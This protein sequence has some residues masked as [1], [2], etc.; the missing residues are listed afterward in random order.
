[1]NNLWNSPPLGPTAPIG[2]I[3][4]AGTAIRIELP[5]SQHQLAIERYDALRKHI[6]RLDSPLHDRVR[7]F[8]PQGSMAIRATITSRKRTDGFDIDIIAELILPNSMKP[9]E[10]L[11]ML[12]EAI[13]GP[14]GSKYHG[15]VERQTRCITVYYSDGMHLDVTPTLLIDAY[16]PRL[17]NLFHAKPGEPSAAHRKFLM[18]SFAFCEWF[19]QRTPVDIS[20]EMAY[21][22]R[23]RAFD[24]AAIRADADVEP[25]P[26]HSTL[27]GGKSA[28]VVA[29]QLLKRNRNLRYEKRAG[30]MPP[31]VMM[32]KIAG[33]ATVPSAS[34]SG[35]L[36]AIAT[37]MLSTLE[38][39]ERAGEIVDVRN[40]RCNEERFT[41]RWPEDRQAQR[42][43]IDDLKLFQRQLAILMSEQ[44]SLDQKRDVLIS[45]FGE[46]PGQSTI[47]EYA[48]NIGRAIESGKRITAP[49]GKVLTIAGL[50]T[51]AITGSALAQPRGHTFYGSSWRKS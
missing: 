29:L 33:E 24:R 26:A 48:A 2:E 8:Y 9:S 12:F 40:P 19:N 22:T 32:A 11:D 47:D 21:S 35:A 37:A 41:D 45:M 6:E 51:P 16:D 42:V 34:I 17:S 5:P 14:T 23:V 10:I 25:V 44:A 13:N 50:A 30:R 15:M 28:G 39:A 1:M 43:Y 4:L 46:G 49:S 3:L 20:F 7:I 27:D 36:N 38:E 31:S 18:N